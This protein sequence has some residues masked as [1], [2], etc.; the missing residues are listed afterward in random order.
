MILLSH[1]TGNQNVRQ[2]L[3]AFYDADLLAEYVTSVATFEGNVFGYLAKSK[4]GGEFERRRYKQQ[5]ADITKLHP[6]FEMARKIASKLKISWLT[7]NETGLFSVNAIYRDMD[8]YAGKRIIKNVQRGRLSAVY[9]YENGALQMFES[10]KSKGLKC[11]YELPIAYWQTSRQLL[12]EEA[13][14]LPQWSGTL[15]GLLVFEKIFARK[16]RELE[17]ADVIICPSDFVH[18]SLPAHIRKSKPTYIIP[19]G[20]PEIPLSKAALSAK[21]SKPLKVLFAGTMTQRKGLSDL[22]EAMKLLN[23][24]NFELHVLG[25]PVVELDFYK[26]QYAEFI[27]HPPCSHAEVLKLMQSCD[28]F[29]LPSIVEGRALVQ[30]EA[31]ACGL[32][33]I[34][35]KNAGA[36]DLVADGT[37]GFLVPI[38]NPNAIAER[39]NYLHLN[40]DKLAMMKVAAHAKSQQVTWESYRNG[41][42]NIVAEHST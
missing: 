9:G 37:A 34:V 3:Q 22:F 38:R 11:I 29:V 41:L 8:R 12:N 19:F 17:L 40:R 28:V 35:T 7:H 31:L 15:E 5:F 20:S 23:T 25:S 6:N 4:I 18:D 33:I 42:V 30:Q 14:R 21:S 36:E 16:D 1:P 13:H 26:Q 24:K 32:P 10:A 39:L 2:A 27:H